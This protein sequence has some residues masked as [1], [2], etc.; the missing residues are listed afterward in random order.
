VV[1]G[2]SYYYQKHGD[3]VPVK[4]HTLR[5]SQLNVGSLYLSG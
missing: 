4:Y 5:T 1:N 2:W 3:S